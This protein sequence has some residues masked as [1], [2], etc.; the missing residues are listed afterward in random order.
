MLQFSRENNRYWMYS[1][2]LLLVAELANG[3]ATSEAGPLGQ[4]FVLDNGLTVLIAER[5]SLPLI[6]VSGLVN[7]G[8]SVEPQGQ[9]GLANLVAELLTHGTT[10]RSADQ[11]NETIDYIG[12]SLHSGGNRE[13]ASLSLLVLEKDLEVGLQLLSDVILNPVFPQEE[14]S[15]KVQEIEAS[16]QKRKEDPASLA[17]DLFRESLYGNHW[18]GRLPDGNEETLKKITRQDLIDFHKAFY[19]PNNTI[20]SIVGAVKTQEL[21]AK[22][23]LIFSSWKKQELPVRPFSLLQEQGKAVYKTL[24]R[25]ITQA[26]IVWGHYG[27]SRDHP[28]Y[29]AVEVMNYIL[30]GGSLNS[31]L[32]LLLREK[33]GLVY[34]VYSTFNAGKNAGPFVIHLQTRNEA[35]N[36]AIGSILKE[37]KRI[38]EKEVEPQ[39]LDLAKAYLTGSFPLRMDTNSKIAGLL[40]SVEYLG[41][42]LDY[43][44][45]YPDLIKAVTAQDVLRVARKCINSEKFV[46]SVVADQDK[47]DLHFPQSK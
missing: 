20:L 25:P 29:Y 23:Q 18:L 34:Y 31:R 46:L 10:T 12:G 28:D 14:I 9:S 24:D 4:R 32:S 7:A 17:S 3:H 30:G 35:A 36:E 45:K 2:V 21:L 16:L 40:T 42:G 8:S 1:M 19:R 22:L 37:L 47:A 38:Q 13:T 26:S 33:M 44:D 39:E 27:V 41:L 6:T 5:P 43:P 15:K 11:I